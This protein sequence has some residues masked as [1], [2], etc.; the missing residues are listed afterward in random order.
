M[1]NIEYVFYFI[2]SKSQ[3]VFD[4]LFNLNMPEL[5]LIFAGW[6]FLGLVFLILT[7]IIL[8][9]IRS[10]RKLEIAE[11]AEALKNLIG[12]APRNERWEKILKYFDSDNPSDWKLAI[13][14]ADTL[15]DELVTRTGYQGDNL[16]EKLKS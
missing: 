11:F 2:Y 6:I 12:K 16:G 10:L 15:L 4:W 13:L 14:E 5:R 7:G 1:L 3:T 8:S 9:K